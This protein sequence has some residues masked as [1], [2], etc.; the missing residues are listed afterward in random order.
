MS[1]CVKGKNLGVKCLSNVEVEMA[2]NGIMG[3]DA[4]HMGKGAKLTW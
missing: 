3:A 4:S 1:V 2:L